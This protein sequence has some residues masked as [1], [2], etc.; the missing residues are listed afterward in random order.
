[1]AVAVHDR[2][3][4]LYAVYVGIVHLRMQDPFDASDYERSK[5]QCAQYV[6]SSGQKQTRGEAKKYFPVMPWERYRD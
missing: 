6:A 2:D 3:A 4:N 5:L 1:M